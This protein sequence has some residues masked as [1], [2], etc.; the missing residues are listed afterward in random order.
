ME[1]LTRCHIQCHLA[2][3]SM[4]TYNKVLTHHLMES[5]FAQ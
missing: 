4:S 5:K 1:I 2:L 3:C